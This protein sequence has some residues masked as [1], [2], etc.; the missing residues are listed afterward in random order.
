MNLRSPENDDGIP[1]IFTTSLKE[2]SKL[3]EPNE[4]K[5]VKGTTSLMNSTKEHKEVKN[6]L[7]I[8]KSKDTFATLNFKSDWFGLFRQKE[9]FR[10]LK[11]YGMDDLPI[12]YL[13]AEIKSD[14]VIDTINDIFKTDIHCKLIGEFVSVKPESENI[15]E[16]VRSY[17]VNN[18]LISKSRFKT[19]TLNMVSL[20]D[21]DQTLS[22][23]VPN[24]Q[25]YIQFDP[26]RLYQ[27]APRPLSVEIQHH[28]NARHKAQTKEGKRQY[29]WTKGYKK[30]KAGKFELVGV[31]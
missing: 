17:P 6:G 19:R 20:I 15:V 28:L 30:T 24:Y 1:S 12:F 31:Y 5:E 9:Y 29:V 11:E 8:Y 16:M 10:E 3:F 7:K 21:Y 25:Y 23:R 18:Y 13:K 14:A 2:I 27:N 22:R 4:I 26:K